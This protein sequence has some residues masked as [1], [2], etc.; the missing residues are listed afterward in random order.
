MWLIF[1]IDNVYIQAAYIIIAILFAA[2]MYW[3]LKDDDDIPKWR[4]Y[5]TC[6]VYAWIWPMI[7]GGFCVFKML[8]IYHERR[9]GVK[10][11]L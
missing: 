6:I 8:L 7:L 10:L 2:F 4:F 5:P 11:K 1:E 3:G 9:Y